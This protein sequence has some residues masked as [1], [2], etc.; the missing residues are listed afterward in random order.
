VSIPEGRA[1]TINCARDDD[2]GRGVELGGRGAGARH[3]PRG[4]EVAE[5]RRTGS[6]LS[7][8]TQLESLS[9]HSETTLRPG[10]S[11]S[12]NFCGRRFD[13]KCCRTLSPSTNN[14]KAGD[15]VFAA[16]GINDSGTAHGPVSPSDFQKQMGVMVDEVA[17]KKA[18]FIPTTSSPLQAWSGG[19]ETNDRLQPYC[20]R[21]WR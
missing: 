9:P 5:G 17:A 3:G 6:K 20:T 12:P 18:T 19:K 15:Y 16:F 10:G 14:V 1:S 13:L 11:S 2:M 4:R 7:D 21:R 8:K